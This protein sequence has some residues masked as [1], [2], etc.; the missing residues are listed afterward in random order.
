[1]SACAIYTA[2]PA[3][4]IRLG[5]RAIPEV[6]EQLR[7]VSTVNQ[8]LYVCDALELTLTTRDTGRDRLLGALLAESLKVPAGPKETLHEPEAGPTIRQTQASVLSS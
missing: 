4:S 2:P 6:D 1:M 8:L 3:E 5:V 7:V